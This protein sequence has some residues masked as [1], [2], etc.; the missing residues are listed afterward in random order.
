MPATGRVMFAEERTLHSM[1]NLR[2]FRVSGAALGLSVA[3]FASS[4]L[5]ASPPVVLGGTATMTDM[6][7]AANTDAFRAAGG[8]LYAHQSGWVPNLV[9]PGDAANSTRSQDNRKA[10]VNL[11]KPN[12]VGQVE[13]SY[14]TP[15][16]WTNA[17]RAYY[18]FNGLT[19]DTASIN[20]LSGRDDGNTS[21]NYPANNAAAF[22][23]IDALKGEGIS[24]VNIILSP[25]NNATDATN[26]KFDNARWDDARARATYGGGWTSDAPPGYFFN[27]RDQNYRDWV[28]AQ[29]KWTNANG[30]KSV[31]I[32]SPRTSGSQ[33]FNQSVQYVRYFE[34]RD[35]I[36]KQW[37]VE[38]YSY[39][40]EPPAN[41]VNRI[42]SEDNSD[43]LAYTAKWL[44][45][46]VQGRAQTLDL[47]ASNGT[48]TTGRTAFST[49]P[50][51]NRVTL[52]LDSTQRT[53][54]INLENLSTNL[55]TDFYAAELSALATGDT[56][57]WAYTF[58][59]NGADITS[60]VFGDGFTLGGAN[61]LE[62][63][64]T[65]VFTLTV[66]RL[67]GA[68][69]AFALSL[70]SRAN[71]NATVVADTISFAAAVPEPTAI[72]MVLTGATLLLR[73]RRGTGVAA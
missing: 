12:T 50:A 15:A 24:K 59:F 23:Y 16:D 18:V 53:F 3:A 2:D 70:Y 8:G 43:N 65:G 37:V 30:L 69:G 61:L 40:G 63:G 60:A 32:I 71:P 13:F 38:N 28:I 54:T 39:V 66:Q 4:S 73:R 11:F 42:G 7:I 34:A 19:A 29:T 64:K 72:G 33:F 6:L 22:T 62:A 9:Y 58:R 68:I 17:Y 49:A 35:A 5:A 55:T 67:D 47:W 10:I 21:S 20:F 14:G 25:N 45:G 46:H 31:N 51:S 57:H 36:P 52:P 41:Y 27:E 44:I 56:S 26:F 1:I 48:T